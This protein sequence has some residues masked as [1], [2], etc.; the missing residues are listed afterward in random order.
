MISPLQDVQ[1][2][3]DLTIVDGLASLE[4]KR[5]LKYPPEK[6]W[7]ML[8]EPERF[9]RWNPGILSFEARP[10]GAL[11]VKIGEQ[12]HWKGKVLAW[13]PHR[14]FE[15]EFNHAPCNEMPEGEHSILRWE[16]SPEGEGTRL[17]FSHSRLS[18]SEGFAAGSHV[19]LDRLRE[20]LGE[21]PLP[22]FES[23][24]A[25][26]ESH[27]LHW[28]RGANSNREF[29]NTHVFAA[30]RERVFRAW[31]DPK[32]ISQWWGPKGFTNSFDIFDFKA[33]GQWKFTMH[34]PDGKD[35][36]NESVFEEI[37]PPSRIVLRHLNFPFFRLTAT[38]EEFEGK[39]LLSWQMLF[40]EVAHYETVKPFA[41]LGNRQNLE[42]L[43][44]HLLAHP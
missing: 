1:N 30:S 42:K 19:M 16:L 3:G 6:V 33:G 20:T 26:L 22:E 38:F 41:V 14:L 8:T 12:F 18:S 34:G 2:Y 15:H 23:S 31:S 7:S 28:R 9:R 13:E 44:A 36:P 4:F 27:Y 35:Y 40:E 43:E 25:A 32:E 29:M 17:H 10:G 21:A 5:F 24:Y 11:E 39:T 37:L